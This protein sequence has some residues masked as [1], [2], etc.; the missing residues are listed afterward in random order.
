M[1]AVS[2]NVSND[3]RLIKPVKLHMCRQKHYK[4]KEDG[5]M[6]PGVHGHGLVALSHSGN[7]ITRIGL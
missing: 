6:A 5:R 3:V 4:H 7:V 1:I 2:L